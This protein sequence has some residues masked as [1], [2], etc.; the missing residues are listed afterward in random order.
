[1]GNLGLELSLTNVIGSVGGRFKCNLVP[2][3]FPNVIA[4]V[5]G[6]PNFNLVP[7]MSLVLI[8]MP[9]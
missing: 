2:I 9:M 3:F 8:Q 1:M 7:I 6:N 5:K 4:E